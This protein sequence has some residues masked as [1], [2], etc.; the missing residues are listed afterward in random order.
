MKN[1]PTKHDKYI[2]VF[3]RLVDDL[4]YAHAHGVQ[5]PLE[6]EHNNAAYDKYLAWLGE[7]TR[8]KL[9][10][11][12]FNA[13]EVYDMA[14]PDA[15]DLDQMNYFKNLRQHC[16]RQELAPVVNW[17]VSVSSLKLTTFF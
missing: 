12:A 1:W 7:M 13:D 14:D 15:I 11:P 16:Q 4:D 9:L 2:T 17:V 5:Q 6:W 3:E 8:L 10:P